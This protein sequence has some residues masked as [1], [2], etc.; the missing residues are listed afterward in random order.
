MT[1]R[2]A[3]L[4]SRALGRAADMT[5][6]A[7]LV[8]GTGWLVE[9]FLGINPEHCPDVREWWHVRARLCGFMPYAIPVAGVI[10]PPLYR[11]LFFTITGQT[12]GMALVGLRLLRSDG[13]HVR[14][15][16]AL[17]RVAAFYFTLGLGSLLVPLSARR[18][19]LHDILAGT[20]VVYD[21][22]RHDR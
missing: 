14:L 9:Q 16:Q 21:R 19:A 6:L 13:R 20:V 15:R 11:V 4:V 17:K 1:P 18:R 3:G 12:P 7:I 10:I 8:A 22:V 5:L 2:Y